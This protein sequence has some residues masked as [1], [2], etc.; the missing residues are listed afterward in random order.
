ME[1]QAKRCKGTKINGSR[2]SNAAK[3]GDYCAK[4]AG[5]TNAF[6]RAVGTIGSVRDTI[7]EL[8]RLYDD[9]VNGKITWRVAQA[10]GRI[11]HELLYGLD[12][13]QKHEKIQED[14]DL[15]GNIRKCKE[16]IYEI[17][18]MKVDIEDKTTEDDQ[19][20]KIN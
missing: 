7:S 3:Y 4:H 14:A 15:A 13:L 2:C 18:G 19:S 12:L 8:G 17:Y 11:L 1:N 6:V 20:E 5:N 10:C 16:K 9:T